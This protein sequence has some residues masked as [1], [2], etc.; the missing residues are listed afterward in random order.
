MGITVETK[1]VTNAIYDS[2]F[3]KNHFKLLLF[4]N[5]VIGKILF[6]TK[7]FQSVFYAHLEPT[8]VFNINF[9]KES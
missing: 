9:S 8:N 3:K 6:G 2:Y 5:Y 7:T 1:C 4:F